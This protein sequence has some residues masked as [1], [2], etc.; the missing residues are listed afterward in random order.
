MSRNWGDSITGM[1][2]SQ[3]LECWEIGNIITG[4]SGNLTVE[5]YFVNVRRNMEEVGKITKA[6]L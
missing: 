3:L 6:N 5:M 1:S 4:N 2:E